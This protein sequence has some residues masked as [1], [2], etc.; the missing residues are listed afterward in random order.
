METTRLRFER[1]LRIAHQE[2]GDDSRSVH[3]DLTASGTLD[4][5][6]HD[7]G[8]TVKRTWGDNMFECGVEFAPADLPR[9]AF[10]LI[11]EH[12]AGDL[13][14]VRKIAKLAQRHG[15]EAETWDWA[16]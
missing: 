16:W 8:P 5:S 14:A 9:L 7:T 12:Y 3:V 15:I 13:D 4:V 1:S 10:A 6:G 2:G 11:A